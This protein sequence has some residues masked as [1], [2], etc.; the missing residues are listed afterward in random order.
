MN[1]SLFK[2]GRCLA[3]ASGTPSPCIDHGLIRRPSIQAGGHSWGTHP[4]L[5]SPS[6][7]PVPRR[8]HAAPTFLTRQLQGAGQDEIP[9]HHTEF[10]EDFENKVML[11][12]EIVEPL[13]INPTLHG[14]ISH[15]PLAVSTKRQGRTTQDLYYVEVVDKDQEGKKL[16]A[17]QQKLLQGRRVHVQGRLRCDRSPPQGGRTPEP[18]AVVEAF[19]FMLV[20]LSPAAATAQHQPGVTPPPAAA[21]PPAAQEHIAAAAAA[22]SPAAQV[23]PAA[24][25]AAQRRPQQAQPQRGAQQPRQGEQATAPKPRAV[26]PTPSSPP[27][28]APPRSQTAGPSPTTPSLVLPQQQGGEV[29]IS[30]VPLW[31]TEE[32]WRLVA[33]RPELWFDNRTSKTNPKA[34]DFKLKDKNRTIN[35]ALWLESRDTPAWAKDSLGY[36][37]F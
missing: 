3:L 32:K 16:K 19:H 11:S 25:A 30:Q 10:N 14:C 22:A 23:R 37:D 20:P 26:S 4:P 5:T 36:N 33:A 27:P 2:S 8:W 28:P 9:I 7:T 31:S 12:G 34:P 29:D 1:T 13:H 21:A 15:F 6:S 35:V 24:A 18:K 17:L